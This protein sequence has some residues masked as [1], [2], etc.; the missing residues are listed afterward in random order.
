MSD[1][2][3][4]P[5]AATPPVADET[6]PAA[7]GRH[8]ALGIRLLK[9][10]AAVYAVL[11]VLYFVHVFTGE[12]AVSVGALEEGMRAWDTIVF[13]TPEGARV[14]VDPGEAVSDHVAA[15]AGRVFGPDGQ[16]PFDVTV[17]KEGA[18]H[19]IPFQYVLGIWNFLGLALFLY[20]AVGDM[21]PQMLDAHRRQVEEEIRAAREAIDEAKALQRRGEEVRAELDAERKRLREQAETE[22]REEH[23]RTLQRTRDDIERMRA[24]H[25]RQLA[26]ELEATVERLRA[27]VARDAVRLAREELA[28]GVDAG[29]Q[30]KLIDRFVHEIREG[31]L[32]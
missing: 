3:A 31:R 10:Y 19:A 12:Q 22:A 15:M 6:A 14:E 26:A 4:A 27:R 23:E 5:T 16:E 21:L 28:G 20:T 7:S 24:A 29:E 18:I 32:A 17:Y 25:E 2:T 11:I 13:E 1:P 30:E 8:K 9:G